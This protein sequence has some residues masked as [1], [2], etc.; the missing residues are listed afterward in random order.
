LLGPPLPLVSTPLP[1]PTHRFA[2]SA[3]TAKSSGAVAPVGGTN[4]V[5]VVSV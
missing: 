1:Y 3:E 2:P 5:R 4:L